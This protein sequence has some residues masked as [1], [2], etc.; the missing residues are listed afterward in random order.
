M[1][2]AIII[3]GPH[4]SGKSLT[5]NEHL[6]GLLGIRKRERLF[7][8]NGMRGVIWS[9]SPEEADRDII[10]K[11]KDKVVERYELFV[12]PCRPKNEEVSLFGELH[13]FFAEHSVEVKTLEIQKGDQAPETAAAAFKFLNSN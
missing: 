10:T 5:I 8:L 6:K 9:Q 12:L 2:R 4:H 3:V 13:E 11:L 1:K 7:Q